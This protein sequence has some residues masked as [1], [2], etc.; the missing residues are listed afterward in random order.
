[1][2]HTTVSYNCII[3]SYHAIASY[4]RGRGYCGLKRIVLNKI[5]SEKIKINL[6][7]LIRCQNKIYTDN[8]KKWYKQIEEHQRSCNFQ[9]GQ[10]YNNK[11]IFNPKFNPFFNIWPRYRAFQGIHQASLH[12]FGWFFLKNLNFYINEDFKYQRFS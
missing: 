5:N 11:N 7:L 1:M 6:F 2:H 9:E 8:G 10:K 3:N 4:K 12:L